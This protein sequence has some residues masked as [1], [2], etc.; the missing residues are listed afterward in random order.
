MSFVYSADEPDVLKTV[1]IFT[2]S[3]APLH[4]LWHQQRGPSTF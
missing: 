3:F 2:V 4:L 1:H